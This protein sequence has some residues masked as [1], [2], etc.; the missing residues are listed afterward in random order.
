[1]LDEIA[2]V[3]S[4]NYIQDL[5][6]IIR[7]HA[8]DELPFYT[9]CL[10]GA[11]SRV[12]P[13]FLRQG[14]ADFFWHCASTVPKWMPKVVLSNGKAESE[15]SNNLLSLWKQVHDQDFVADQVMIH[16][17]DESRHSRMFIRMV[18]LAFPGF[19]TQADLDDFERS[20][21]DVRKGSHEKLVTRLPTNHIIDHLVQM[22]I[23][24]IRTRLHMHLFAPV[25]HNFA[26]GE[27]KASIRGFLN[28]LVGDEVRHISYT[29]LLMER[30]AEAG[31]FSL[32]KN[33]YLG[34]LNTFNKITIEQT[35]DAVADYGA[36]M[37]PDLLEM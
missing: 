14:Y 18:Q 34:R 23:G 12:D 31:D 21:P 36:G 20:L 32:I 16:A 37:F 15:G 6:A 27:N 9:D 11:Y 8:Q 3:S 33:L 5:L 30:W 7:E 2:N 24:E 4:E 1:M 35:R 28:T 26:P 19:A 29:A 22:N 17:K 13:V 25:I 10:L